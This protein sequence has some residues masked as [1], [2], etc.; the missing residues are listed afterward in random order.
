LV[1]GSSFE[2]LKISA[3]HTHRWW[4][5]ILAAPGLWIQRITTRNPNHDQ[6]EVARIAV[7][8]SLGMPLPETV[9]VED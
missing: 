8:S 2:L 1:A 7:W 3:G 5:R 6:L 4:W 9:T